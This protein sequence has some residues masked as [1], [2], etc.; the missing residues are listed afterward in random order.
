MG[1]GR[2]GSG[3]G[4]QR[5]PADD[6]RVMLGCEGYREAIS[7]RIDGED[8]GL[9]AEPLAR[10]LADCAGCRAFETDALGATRRA[11]LRS[12][13]PVPDLTGA[14]MTAISASRRPLPTPFVIRLTLAL[15]AA[16]QACSA[17]PA[18]VGNDSGATL[19]I[20]HEQGAWG[21][22][23]AAGLAFAA[24]RPARAGALLPFL[25]V[26][27][28][29][30]A[31][32]TLVDVV[33]GRVAPTAEVPHLMAAIGLALL[34]LEMHPPAALVTTAPLPEARLAA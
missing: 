22:A 18:L 14:I 33:T 12:A 15:V 28:A 30:M 3:A 10:H 23:L 2:S 20:A 13:E 31:A 5:P 11:R 1:H 17:I 25:A 21:L 27:V 8:P 32:L 19:H 9:A 7:A 26:F 4:N 29:T 34:W 6:Y 24:W 16:A